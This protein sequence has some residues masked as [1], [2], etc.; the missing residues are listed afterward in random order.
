MAEKKGCEGNDNAKKENPFD[1][2]MTMHAHKSELA[3]WNLVAKQ[4]KY[5]HR[6]EFVREA[7][8]EKIE[9]LNK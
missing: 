5:K 7:I 4:H 2:L 8:E 6:S 3:L 1:G 9:S